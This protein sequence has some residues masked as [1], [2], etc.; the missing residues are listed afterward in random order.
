MNAIAAT[1]SEAA[2]SDKRGVNALFRRVL[3]P[4]FLLSVCPP[5]AIVVWHTHAPWTAGLRAPLPDVRSARGARRA[6]HIWRP[7]FFGTPTAWPIIGCFAAFELPLMRVLPGPDFQWPIT[8]DGN[9]PVYKPTGRRPSSTS[10]ATCCRGAA[11]SACTC[12]RRASSTI[13]FGA[14]LG[15]LNVFSLVFCLRS[16]PQGP[17]LPVERDARHQRQSHLRLLLGHRAATRASSAGT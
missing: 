2:P 10:L 15:A 6:A 7:V 9:V 4:L 16:L 14:I 17:L 13:I 3:M 11:P 5:F 8:P 1:T 12:S